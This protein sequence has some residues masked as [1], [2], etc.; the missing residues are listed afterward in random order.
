VVH[1]LP[2]RHRAELK[3][4]RKLVDLEL[5]VREDEEAV[6]VTVE[7]AVPV[8][9]SRLVQVGLRDLVR[10]LRSFGKALERSPRT[11]DHLREEGLRDFLIVILN[12]TYEGTTTGETFNA[13][14]KT[15]L[16]LRY[17]DANA[18]MGECKVWS[19]EA[20]LHDALDQ[21]LGDATW[22]DTKA[23]L[24]IFIKEQDATAII[25][26]AANRA[27]RHPCYVGTD[28]DHR[29]DEIRYR[30]HHPDDA[31]RIITVALLPFVIVGGPVKR[32]RARRASGS[33]ATQARRPL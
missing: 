12:A 29:P 15:D 28:F 3:L 6:A 4:E 10:T 20:G 11:F 14:G 22:R 25:N 33:D 2:L 1:Q 19:G 31:E 21:M 16:L 30:F 8:P 27:V 23:A 17:Q 24:I 18:F 13:K 32:T 7:R 5:L 26:K 9:T